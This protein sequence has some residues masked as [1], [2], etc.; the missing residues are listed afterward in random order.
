MRFMKSA[1]VKVKQNYRSSLNIECAFGASTSELRDL[2]GFLRDANENQ[3][4]ENV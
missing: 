3:E 1:D 4:F 2:S